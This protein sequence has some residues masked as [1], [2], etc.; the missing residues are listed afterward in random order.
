MPRAVIRFLEDN[1]MSNNT[2]EI[3]T[4]NSSKMKEIVIK[5]IEE[6]NLDYINGYMGFNSGRIE[7]KME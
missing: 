5:V 3:I 4:G 7:V 1:W 2:V 6:Y